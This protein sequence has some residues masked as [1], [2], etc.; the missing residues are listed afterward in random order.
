M[1]RMM[2]T[3]EKDDARPCAAL[4]LGVQ[5]ATKKKLVAFLE[6]LSAHE[7]SSW[8]LIVGMV[9]MGFGLLGGVQVLRFTQA[10]VFFCACLFVLKIKLKL[11]L[12]SLIID[13]PVA[14]TSYISDNSSHCDAF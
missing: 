6:Q 2:R 9:G 12:K 5:K 14:S 10:H 3:G 11:K 1:R 4:D 7:M 13:R 8:L